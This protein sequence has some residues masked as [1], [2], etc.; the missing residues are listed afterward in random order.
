[1]N[2][3]KSVPGLGYG[4]PAMG[5]H[6]VAVMYRNAQVFNSDRTLEQN[7]NALLK[8]PLFDQP[9]SRYRYGVSYD[10][11]GYLVEVISGMPFAE[12]LGKRIFEPL[13]MT[14]TGFFVPQEKIDRFAAMYGITEDGSLKA[15]DVPEVSP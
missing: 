5:N 7:V 2:L 9:G 3:Q 6:P 4:F 15:V 8:I 14:D 1:M 13:G 10:V 12:F 11:L